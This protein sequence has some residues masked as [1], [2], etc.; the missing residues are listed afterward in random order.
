[1]GSSSQSML[2][3]KIA[4]TPGADSTRLTFRRWCSDVEATQFSTRCAFLIRSFMNTFDRRN[5]SFEVVC[6]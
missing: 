5:D 6:E 3:G 2:M 4:R 1:M